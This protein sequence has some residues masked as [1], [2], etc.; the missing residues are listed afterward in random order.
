MKRA[1]INGFIQSRA[2]KH[3]VDPMVSNGFSIAAN[4]GIPL[5]A[6]DGLVWAESR[7]FNHR[8]DSTDTH[9][10]AASLP[11]GNFPR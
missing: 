2:E 4:S 1:G 11:R 10:S 7:P 8:Q 5:D 9:C 3:Y 6:K